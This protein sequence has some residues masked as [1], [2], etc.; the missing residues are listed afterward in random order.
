MYVSIVISTIGY[1]TVNDV[2][3]YV[4]KFITKYHPLAI[5][6]LVN[7]KKERFDMLYNITFTKVKSNF[8][9]LSTTDVKII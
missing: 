8:Q 3:L 4:L 5:L 1:F 6:Q 9:K 7:F 2:I